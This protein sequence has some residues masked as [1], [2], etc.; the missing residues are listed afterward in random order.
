MW[1]LSMTIISLLV[2]YSLLLGLYLGMIVSDRRWIRNA[3][4]YSGVIWKKGKM[5]K[6][7]T[8]DTWMDMKRDANR[9]RAYMKREGHN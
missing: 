3:T 1:N 8:G 4:E 2:L 7:L 9:W 5:Y 6:V